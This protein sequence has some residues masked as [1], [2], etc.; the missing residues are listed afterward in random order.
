MCIGAVPFLA[1]LFLA[2]K[3]ALKIVF[4]VMGYGFMG[5]KP[6]QSGTNSGTNSEQK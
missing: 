6:E 1:N 5:Q 3:T 4:E 2:L